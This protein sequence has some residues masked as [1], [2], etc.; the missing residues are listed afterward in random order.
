MKTLVPLLA[1]AASPLFA[2]VMSMSTGDV[3]VQG[4]RARYELRMPVYEIAH[5]KNPETSLFEHI[6][7]STAVQD[8]RLTQKSCRE[9]MS[10]GS[11]LCSAD[12]E[13][14][15]PVDRLDVECTFHT[16]TVPNHVHL[17]RAQKDDKADQA[18]FDYSASKAQIRFEPPTPLE[19]AV[20][21]T[22][23]GLMRALGGLAQILFLA[24]L[25]L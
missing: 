14:P 9:D 7:F 11:Y 15:I 20:T 18:I 3:M 1:I 6:R 21:E 23:A 22:A 12:Y 19:T 13:F 24:T 17:L 2:H 25:A 10:Q 8:G 16:V 4:N 5:V